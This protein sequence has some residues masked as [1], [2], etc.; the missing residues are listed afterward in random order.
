MI[1]VAKVTLQQLLT[2]KYLKK[3][4]CLIRGFKLPSEIADNEKGIT[5]YKGDIIN[6]EL[7][8]DMLYRHTRGWYQSA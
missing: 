4:F 8:E 7:V 3:D 5:R 6:T 1:Q 2:V